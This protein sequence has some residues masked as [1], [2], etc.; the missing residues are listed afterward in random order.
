MVDAH[1][2]VKRVLRFVE[3][4]HLIRPGDHLLVAVSG[5][6]DSVVLL[7]VLLALQPI[8]KVAKLTTVH[9]DHQLRGEESRQD[10]RFVH[11]LAE[12]W[13]VACHAETAAVED[14]RCTHG[15]SLEMAA[16][17]CRQRFFEQLRRDLRAQSVALG[18]HADDQAEEILLR[19]LRGTGPA[20]LSGMAARAPQGL[21]R[22][23]LFATREEV[24]EYA[25]AQQ[26]SYRMDSSNVR[27]FCQRNALRMEVLPLLGSYFHPRVVRTLSR[28]AELARDEEEVW[29][30]IIEGHWQ[31][32]VYQ[33][34]TC[35]IAVR[36]SAM[37]SLPVAVQRRLLRRAVER[38]Q[39]NLQGVRAVHIEALRGLLAPGAV[40]KQ[41]HLPGGLRGLREA[42]CLAI[43]TQAA[44]VVEP[45]PPR[46]ITA[47]GRHH[48]PTFTLELTFQML[49]A[50]QAI[51]AADLPRTPDMVWLDADQIR[52]PLVVRSWQPGDRFQPLGLQGSM[53]LQ[54]YFTNTRV[55]REQRQQI[56]LLCDQEKICWVMG[57]R[58]DER[59]KITATTRR[60]LVVATTRRRSRTSS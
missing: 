1:P 21:I 27:S 52:W 35:K 25:R 54:D 17:S 29:E 40:G 18:H 12:R 6:P 31:R 19:L 46:I 49:A 55:P 15:V 39:G 38:V 28:C 30:Q 42:E 34:E 26:L 47:S 13:G 2:F 56:P 60:V 14:Y 59:V 24:L 10:A 57:R 33:E 5:G 11:D 36:A 58:L 8:L 7:H 3:A 53:K 48:F 22:P 51:S 23:L 20:G 41:V 32:V 44:E 37:T 9:L 4:R 45:L 16:R 50:D 43:R